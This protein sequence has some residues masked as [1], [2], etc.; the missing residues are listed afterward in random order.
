MD[1]HTTKLIERRHQ[2]LSSEQACGCRPLNGFLQLAEEK[3]LEITTLDVRNSGDTAGNRDR[4]VG[5]GS[6]TT[7]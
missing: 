4:V 2:A 1:S 7:S 5:Y 3:G 6:Y